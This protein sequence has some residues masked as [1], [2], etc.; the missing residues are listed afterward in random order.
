MATT[1]PTVLAAS[2]ADFPFSPL[3][4]ASNSSSSNATIDHDEGDEEEDWLSPLRL[5]GLLTTVLVP[6]VFGVIVVVGIIGNLLV[7]AVVVTN[8]Q[9]RNTTNVLILSLA[10]ADLLFIVLCVPFTGVDYALSAT[11][12]WPFGLLWCKTV[13]YLI[14]TTNF[15]SIY[16][17]IL[18]SMDRFLAVVYPIVSLPYRTVGNASLATSVTW[19]VIAGASLPIWFTHHLVHD[20]GNE[21]Q[22]CQF[23]Q[24]RYN[25][26][27]WQLAFFV[28]GYAIPLSVI[29]ILYVFMLRRLWNPAVGRQVSKDALRNKRRV[30]KLV[31]V[32]IVVFAVCWAP[33]HFVFVFKAVGIYTTKVPEDFKLI[34]FQILSHVLAYVN[35]CVNPILYAFLSDNFRKA[36][37]HLLPRFCHRRARGGGEGEDGRRPKSAP[38]CSAIR[39]PQ[40]GGDKIAS[41]P[42]SPIPDRRAATAAMA[43]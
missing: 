33:I 43:V 42:T 30:T 7:I 16:T 23:D 4:T 36:F 11:Q 38:A 3:A 2:A 14:Y 15:F 29:V 22:W 37:H 28:S 35:S 5:L 12:G 10:L 18:M 20:P 41:T 8:Q 1:W 21:K 26:P 17:L 13:Q 19:A 31:L 9:M 27:I 40:R 24:E 6:L 34:V 32:V 25:L 39:S